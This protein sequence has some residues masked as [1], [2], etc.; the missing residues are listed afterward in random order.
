M[1]VSYKINC[2]VQAV[3]PQWS[4]WHSLPSVGR[5]KWQVHSAVM[6][7]DI[8]HCLWVCTWVAVCYLLFATENLYKKFLISSLELSHAALFANLNQQFVDRLVCVSYLALRQKSDREKTKSF[9][10]V[11]QTRKETNLIKRYRKQMKWSVPVLSQGSISEPSSRILIQTYSGNLLV[12]ICKIL[13]L[14]K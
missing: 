6:K 2:K 9:V 12:S 10:N 11:S 4:H 8:G 13:V 5:A 3:L 1:E 14:F 7:W